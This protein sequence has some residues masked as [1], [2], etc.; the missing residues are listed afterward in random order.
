MRPKKRGGRRK[1]HEI[2]QRERKKALYK[3][4]PFSFQ[5]HHN[6]LQNDIDEDDFGIFRHFELFGVLRKR[7]SDL[8][9]EPKRR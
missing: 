5:P 4:R 7:Y 1:I 9:I 8:F 3:K 2:K 6:H